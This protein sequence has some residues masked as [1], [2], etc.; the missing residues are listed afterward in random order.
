MA[1]NCMTTEQIKM[2]YQHFGEKSKMSKGST[3]FDKLKYYGERTVLQM[4]LL[5][6]MPLILLYVA[7][8]MIFKDGKLSLRHFFNLKGQNITDYYARQ[9]Q[10]Y[11]GK[12]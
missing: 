10:K 3:L 6:I 4:I 5:L 12:D 11:K 9:Q 2:L 1:C 8:I 7:Y